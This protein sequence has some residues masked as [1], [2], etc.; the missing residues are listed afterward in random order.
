[1][2]SNAITIL[3][4]TVVIVGGWLVGCL[5]GLSCLSYHHHLSGPWTSVF[6]FFSLIRFVFDAC[7]FP[8]T[9]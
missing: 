6:L 9:A 3:L 4:N 5:V 8:E 1:M 7:G 2:R